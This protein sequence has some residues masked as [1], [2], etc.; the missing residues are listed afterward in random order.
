MGGFVDLAGRK[1]GRL[2]VLSRDELATGRDTRWI[3][4]CECGESRSV[5]GG[6]LS[7][8]NTKS[9]GC[10]VRDMLVNR[11]RTHGATGTRLH[12]IWRGMLDRTSNPKTKIYKHYGARGITVCVEWSSF[13]P[14]REWAVANGY[15]DDLTLDRINNDGPYS[16]ANCRWA[17]WTQQANNRRKQS[18]SQAKGD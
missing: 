17:T 11:N 9:C 10:G 18:P 13:E 12:N 3:C 7:R 16:P 1:F 15:D 14:F 2:T 4:V 5:F 8:G 6:N